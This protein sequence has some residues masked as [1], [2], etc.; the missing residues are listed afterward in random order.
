MRHIGDKRDKRDERDERDKRNI[1]DKK[2]HEE[3]W[4]EN[5]ENRVLKFSYFI[6]TDIQTYLPGD[7]PSYR[8]ARTHLKTQ[9]TAKYLF[10]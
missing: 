5:L 2:I 8:D 10:F 1:R 7:R 9:K 6:Q 3:K 4:R